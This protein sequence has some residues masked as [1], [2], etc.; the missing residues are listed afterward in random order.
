MSAYTRSVSPAQGIFFDNSTNS[1]I[2]T[3]VQ[4][5]IE[6]AGSGVHL[7]DGEV[8]ATAST[9][10]PSGTDALMTGMT[11]TPVS[12]TYLVWFSC[13]INSPTA[14]AVVSVSI[15][16]GGTQ[17]G[18]SLRKVMPFAG[19]TLTVGNQR[20][21]TGTNGRV[22]VNGS[23]AIEIRWSTSSGTITTSDR[24]MNTLRVG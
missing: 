15:Y 13:D 21:F 20:A 4:A 8:S 19:G 1:Y 24:T 14:G 3:D 5:A 2:A 9:T 16:V 12:G 18:D 6:E 10:A 22:T 11:I 17:K 7:Q 23:Q